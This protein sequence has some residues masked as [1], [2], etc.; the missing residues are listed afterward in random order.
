MRRAGDCVGWVDGDAGDDWVWGW[1]V[2]L[3]DGFLGGRD[4]I[5]KRGGRAVE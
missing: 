1:G 3:A 4:G 5:G 2:T